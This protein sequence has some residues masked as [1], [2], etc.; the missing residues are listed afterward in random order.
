MFQIHLDI[1]N[2]RPHHLI[3]YR[4]IG[5]WSLWTE[6]LHE[7]SSNWRGGG[8]KRCVGG[9]IRQEES[10]WEV[11]RWTVDRATDCGE[12]VIGEAYHTIG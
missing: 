3:C 8:Y 7:I 5:I 9:G 6:V 10:V 4:P 1:Q 12:W 11:D 2:E